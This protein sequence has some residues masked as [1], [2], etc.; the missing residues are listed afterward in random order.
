MTT[1]KQQTLPLSGP[2]R[3]LEIAQNLSAP[4]MGRLVAVT[5]LKHCQLWQ[6]SMMELDFRYKGCLTLG[7]VLD[8]GVK[9]QRCDDRTPDENQLL[10]AI[11]LTV[12][13]HLL[14]MPSDLPLFT[15]KK[16]K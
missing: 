8:K 3:V 7:T 12:R 4:M 15:D 2:E 11:R 13:E 6:G 16:V 9:L 5:H 1:H 10:E 14:A